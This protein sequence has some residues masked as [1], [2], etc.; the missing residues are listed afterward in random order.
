MSEVSSGAVGRVT[1]CSLPDGS[2]FDSSREGRHLA[3]AL[4]ASC[5]ALARQRGF[6]G[7]TPG[8]N[9][10]HRSLSG[11]RLWALRKHG[12]VRRCSGTKASFVGFW[13]SQNS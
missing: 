13:Y 11:L 2:V 7:R 4:P 6:Y 8:S 5:K 1:S 12:C 10:T 9:A 3:Q